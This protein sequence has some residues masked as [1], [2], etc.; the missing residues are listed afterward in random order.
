MKYRDTFVQPVLNQ[1]NFTLQ[2]NSFDTEVTSQELD[3]P[4]SWEVDSVSK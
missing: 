4:S 1:C 3:T 2:I